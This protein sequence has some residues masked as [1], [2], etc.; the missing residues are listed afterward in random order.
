MRRGIL[1]LSSLLLTALSVLWSNPSSAAHL[2]GGDLTYKYI[3]NHRYALQFL[4]YRDA[5]CTNCCTIPNSITYYAY[6]G[7]YVAKGDYS[8]YSTRTVV[9][10]SLSYVKPDAPSCSSPA[11][12][13]AQQG[14]F[15]DTF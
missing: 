7:S 9:R 6:A 8:S 5:N 11:G 14:V 15:L 4:I 3:G 10:Y 1:C 13:N 2:M 12:V